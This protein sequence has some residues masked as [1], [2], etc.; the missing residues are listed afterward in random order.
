VF[1]LPACTK[2][3]DGADG[4][5]QVDGVDANLA[6]WLKEAAPQLDALLDTLLTSHSKRVDRCAHAITSNALTLLSLLRFKLILV[7]LPKCFLT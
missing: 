5:S 1:N 4:A 6:A 7:I 2:P 3:I